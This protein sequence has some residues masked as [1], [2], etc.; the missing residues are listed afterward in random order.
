M[1]PLR[2][3]IAQRLQIETLRGRRLAYKSCRKIQRQ[4]QNWLPANGKRE[5]HTS[6][7]V[8]FDGGRQVEQREGY[9]LP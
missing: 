8:C 1:L 7:P 3:L 5:V 9:F 6:G 4:L 2:I